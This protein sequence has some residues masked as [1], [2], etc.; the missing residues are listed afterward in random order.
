MPAG[1]YATDAERR[2]VYWNNR[3]AAI[4]GLQPKAGMAE[5]QAFSLRGRRWPDGLGVAGDDTPL[6]R[7]LRSGEP[8]PPTELVVG[9]GPSLVVVLASA[10]PLFSGSGGVAGALGV[11]QDVTALRKASQLRD[12][13]LA[14]VSYGLRTPVTVISGMS[15]YLQRRGATIS[16]SVRQDVIQ[17]LVAA[18][19]RMERVTENMLRLFD[20]GQEGFEPEPLLAQRILDRARAQ[21]AIDFPDADVRQLGDGSGLAVLAVEHWAEVAMTNLLENAIQYGD[22]AESPFVEIIADEHDVELRVCNAGPVLTAEGFEALFEP[23]YREP[24]QRA[25]APRAGL[26]LQTARKLAEA[27]GGRVFGGPRP[28]NG[29]PMFTLALPRYVHEGTEPM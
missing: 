28:D 29:G 11:L 21:V 25:R 19:R 2:L 9:S 10:E 6:A 14:L 24:A 26:G 5:S 1:V 17:E 22:R 4:W 12:D 13:L 27:Q 18:S 8:A 23:F 3:A 7:A 16:D 20:I 15:T